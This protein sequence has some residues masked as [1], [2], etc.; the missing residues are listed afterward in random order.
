MRCGNQARRGAI[1]LLLP[2]TLLLAVVFYLYSIPE[3]TIRA[4]FSSSDQ[5]IPNGNPFAFVFYATNAGYAC[6]ALLLIK[7]LSSLSPGISTV[8]MVPPTFLPRNLVPF[9]RF[10]TTIVKLKPPPLAG[11]GDAYYWS[12]L[13][14][15]RAF[16]LQ[17][18][19]PDLK[20]IIVMD[21]DQIIRKPLH[22]LFHLPEVEVAAPVAY[23]L[24]NT[25]YTTS[26][27]MVISLSKRLSKEVTT[28]LT[29]IR[30][31][32]YDMDLVNRLFYP[33]RMLVLP[34][35][36]CTLNSHWESSELPDWMQNKTKGLQGLWEEESQVIHFSAGGK[37]WNVN[38]R[39]M[40]RLREQGKVDGMFVKMVEDWREE[41]DKTCVLGWQGRAPLRSR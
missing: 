6:G 27:L 16:Q 39:R 4:P 20:R 24:E 12:A 18:Q 19:L 36:Y 41:A 8:L 28:A 2:F 14:K 10:N 11:G 33:S 21:S 7:Q 5:P 38:M 23:W 25:E 15:L 17:E 26:A 40:N 35:S 13:L 34:G 31:K 29:T 1:A 9:Q 30:S 22:H 32:E 37:P 3:T